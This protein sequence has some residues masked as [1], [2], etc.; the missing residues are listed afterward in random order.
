MALFTVKKGSLGNKAQSAAD[1]PEGVTFALY[2]NV[3]AII[4]LKEPAE[5]F[6][7]EP[8]QEVP[9]AFGVDS[10]AE[11]FGLAQGEVEEGEDAGGQHLQNVGEKWTHTEEGT[12]THSGNCGLLGKIKRRGS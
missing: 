1:P 7:S 4:V 8:S 12:D 6:S 10:I 2:L 9:H 3:L 11:D 5:Q